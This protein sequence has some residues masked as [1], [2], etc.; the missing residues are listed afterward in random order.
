M[1]SHHEK[2]LQVTSLK[3]EWEI[4]TK[5]QDDLDDTVISRKPLFS[6]ISVSQGGS[7][8]HSSRSEAHATVI[9]HPQNEGKQHV[10]LNAISVSVDA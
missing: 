10:E 3:E 4:V 7:N 6:S 1:E 8:K 9:V 2:G 5:D